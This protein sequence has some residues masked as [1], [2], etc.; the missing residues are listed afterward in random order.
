MIFFQ[1]DRPVSLLVVPL[2]VL[3]LIVIAT[4]FCCLFLDELLVC[5]MSLNPYFGWIQ[6]FDL[7]GKIHLP[8]CLD[9]YFVVLDCGG[10][11]FS[12]IKKKN[13]GHGLSFDSQSRNILIKTEHEW[14]DEK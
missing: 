6:L 12:S 5:F 1:H 7:I 8:L 2:L 13:L 9:H 14:I 4:S 3:S 11:I 10:A